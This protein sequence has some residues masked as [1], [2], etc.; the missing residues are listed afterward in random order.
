MQIRNKKKA[1]GK[2]LNSLFGHDLADKIVEKTIGEGGTLS[3]ESSVANTQKTPISLHHVSE[4][5]ATPKR[6]ESQLQHAEKR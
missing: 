6:E 2:N 1:V 3:Q 4:L 5:N